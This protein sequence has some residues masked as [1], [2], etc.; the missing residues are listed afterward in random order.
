VSVALSIVL[1]C[2]SCSVYFHFVVRFC[3]V[4][5]AF[6]HSLWCALNVGMCH[7][8]VCWRSW[9]RVAVVGF[10][11]FFEVGEYVRFGDSKKG[12]GG[13]IFLSSGWL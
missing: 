8:C 4:C 7:V 9:F 6:Q 13:C 3:M 2:V 5:G 12:S 1:N 10:L 11:G